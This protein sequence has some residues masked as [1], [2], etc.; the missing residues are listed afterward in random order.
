[1]PDNY[2][3]KPIELYRYTTRLDGF[4][5]WYA[6][7]RGGRILTKPFTFEGN[8]LEI[9][10]STS[11]FGDIIIAVCDEDG[12][13]IDGYKSYKIFGDSV[14]RKV[15]FENDLKPLENKPVRLKFELRDCDVYSFKFN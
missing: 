12:N 4:F 10:F 3:I 7:Y 15:K 11:A 14:D 1:M 5:S 8:E 9:N 2:R 6:K 13:E